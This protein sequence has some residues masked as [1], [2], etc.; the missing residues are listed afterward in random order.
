VNIF[1]YD[2]KFPAT[3]SIR[4]GSEQLEVKFCETCWIYRPP[5]AIHC[6]TCD[7]CV[8]RFDHHCPYLGNCVGKRNY[9]Y[10]LLFVY[11]VEIN[12][13]YAIACC[14]TQLYFLLDTSNATVNTIF[15]DLSGIF[16]FIVGI[17]GIIVFGVVGILAR[18]H[19]YL[20]ATNQSTNEHIKKVF[21]GKKN[22]FSRSTL[23]GNCLSMFCPSTYPPYVHPRKK[24]KSQNL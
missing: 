6:G 21:K 8:D 16:S 11:L 2:K 10:F 14:A 18:L 13:L 20:V 12:A 22:P 19:C 3:V 15:H 7:N 1:E 4:V 17:Y 5:R 9:R 24:V 23:F